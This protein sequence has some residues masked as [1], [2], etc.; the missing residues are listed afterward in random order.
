MLII[1]LSS[2]F[3]QNTEGV[4]NMGIIKRQGIKNSI[5]NYVGVIIGALS[6]IF[7]YPLIDPKEIGIVQFVITTAALLSPF[8]G[9]GMSLA[10]VNFFPEVKD[11]TQQHNGFLFTIML[12]TFITTTGVLLLVFLFK[13]PLSDFFKDNKI[14]FLN[15]FPFIVAFTFCVTFSNLLQSYIVNHGRIVIPSIFNNILF[16]ITQ[17]ILVLLYAFHYISFKTILVG[18]LATFII[19][20]V[21]QILYLIYLKEGFF[22]PNF[23]LFRNKAFIKKLIKYANFVVFVGLGGVLATRLDQVIIPP[24]LGFSSVAIFSLGFFISEAIDVPRKAL[25]SI[26]SPL[27]SESMKNKNFVHI[28]EIYQKTAL[29][30]LLLG[31]YLLAGVWACADSLFDLMPS[32]NELY[33]SGKYVILYLGIA[34]LVDMAT[35]VNS[36]IITYSEHY[37]FNLVSLV[38]MALLNIGFNFLFIASWGLNLGIVGSALATLVTMLVFNIWKLIFIYQKIKIHPLQL[39]MLIILLL[40]II[41]WILAWLTPSVFSPILSIIIKGSIVTLVYW[42]GIL[43]FKISDDV[44]GMFKKGIGFLKK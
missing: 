39:R 25:S 6:V 31:V 29:L 7:V 14:T 17:P 12:L 3:T 36:E 40:G 28:K 32:N 38:G 33:R 4:S 20:V 30:Q 11:K 22:L 26:A 37:R 13:I 5:V 23:T 18:L 2:H 34:R 24:L 42:V 9:W 15:T 35:G 44:N 41:A 16:K 27:I 19:A 43:Y 8:T 21:G 10:S 1:I